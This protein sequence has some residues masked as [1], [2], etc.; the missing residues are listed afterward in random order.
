MVDVDSLPH[1]LGLSLLFDPLPHVQH[2]LVCEEAGQ[3][4]GGHEGRH[5]RSAHALLQVHA[6]EEPVYCVALAG[7][8]L[9][10]LSRQKLQGVDK[11]VSKQVSNKEK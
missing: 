4:S 6:H 9:G 1:E 11:D 5:Q 7:R 3:G 2:L 8:Q 10:Y